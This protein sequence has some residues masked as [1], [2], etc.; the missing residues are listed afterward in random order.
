MVSFAQRLAPLIARPPT[1]P[2]DNTTKLSSDTLN[3]FDIIAANR[4]LVDTPDDSPSSSAEYFKTSSGKLQKKV[5]FSPWTKFHR[6]LNTSG[7]DS[8]SDGHIRRLPPSKDCKS[9]KSILKPSTDNG[10]VLS[11]TELLAFDHTSLPAMLRSTTQHLASTSRASRLDAYSTLLACLSAYEE[12]PEGKELVEKVVE[13]TGYIRRDVSAKI[14]EDG[15]L[16]IQLATQALKLLTV[17][18]C[19]P[20]MA[21]MLPEDFCSFILERSIS[22]IEDER[23]PKILVSH[24]MH[25]IE[26]QKFSA[27]VVTTDRANRLLSALD[28]VTT[29]IKGNRVVG[30]RLMIYQRLLTQAK[31]TMTSR[32]GSWIDHLVAGMLSTIKDIRARAIAFG[33]EASL[34]LGTTSSVSQ[35]F[36]ELFNRVSPE[37]KKVVNYLSSRLIDMTSSKEDGVHV[38]QIWS[39]VIL[40]LRSRRRQLECWEHL[41]AWLVIIQ[42]CFNASDA[43][44]KFQANLAWNRLIFAINLDISTSSSMAKMLRQPIVAQLERRSSDKNA[45]SAKQIA[46]SSYCA[47]LYH[48]FRPSATHA[49]LDQYWDLYVSQI[50]PSCFSASKDEVNLACD[51]LAALF[52]NT[53]PAIWDENRANLNGPVKPD[54]LPCLDPK[55]IRLRTASILQTFDKLFD[56]TDWYLGKGQ[57][58]S[59]LVAWRHFVTALGI[60]SSKEVKV[61]METMNAVAHIINEIKSFLERSEPKLL[62]ESSPHQQ[63]AASDMSDDPCIFKNVK[64]LIQEAV[65]KIGAIPFLERRVLLTS[66]DSFEAAETP[67]RRSSRDQRTLSSPATHLLNLLLTNLPKASITACHTEAIKFVMHI[68]LQSLSSRRV[69]LGVLRNLSRMLSVD[70]TFHLQ[71]RVVFWQLLADA[72]ASA[73]RL[74]QQN[75]SHNASPQ[76]PGHEYREAV[77]I[78]ELGIQQGSFQIVPAWLEL[79]NCI[80]DT[81]REEIGAEAIILMV[82]EPLAGLICKEK[83]W[84]YPTLQIA[85]SILDKAHWPQSQQSTERSQKRLWGVVQ[86]SHKSTSLD[87]YDHIY[88]MIDALLNNTYISLECLP[89]EEANTVLFPSVTLLIQSCPPSL[90]VALITRIQGGLGLWIEDANGCL[91]DSRSKPHGLYAEVMFPL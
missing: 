16:D 63:E 50:L 32:V 58:F 27:K 1:P 26:K 62:K 12:V 13:I 74:P 69:Q 17:F 85:H 64:F 15:G 40:F 70:S 39:V 6:P 41:K 89:S 11:G 38:P 87:P 28:G 25:L 19:T 84:G 9:S 43:Q 44:I 31:T 67:S 47:L 2:K 30:H 57:E 14:D 77:K 49:Q 37:G 53:K 52:S 24:Y 83:Q 91:S 65:A 51:I 54:E 10:T 79:H 55:W 42:R 78:L 73:L 4:P 18:L 86:V 75:E 7:K 60:A 35:A 22:S 36:I 90:N 80:V 34:H 45:K 3:G 68:P 29:R 72:T 8:D 61:S 88:S 21:V 82:T 71:A 33:T 5:G 48:A 23:L 76:Y 59:I 56:L 66:Q 46:R 81:L 20:T